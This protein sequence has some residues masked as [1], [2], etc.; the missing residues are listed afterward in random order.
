MI[1]D[2]NIVL[3]VKLMVKIFILLYIIMYD[4]SVL[5]ILFINSIR[6]TIATFA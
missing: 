3:I 6:I 1:V 4:V 5:F 2:W